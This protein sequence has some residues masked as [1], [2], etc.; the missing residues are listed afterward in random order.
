MI[1]N[2][3]AQAARREDLN[4][5]QIA[6]V[7]TYLLDE[8]AEVQVKA[9]FLKALS[10]K[11]ETA[12]EISAFVACCL[13]YAIDPQLDFTRFSGPTIDVCGTGGDQLDLFNVSTTSMF[14]IA[15]GGCTVMK[16]GNR[17][18]TSKSGGA[19][20]LEALGINIEQPAEKLQMI[21]EKAGVAFLFAPQY[22][23]AF[24][25][26]APVRQLLAK[27][28]VKTIFNLIGP[29]LNPA[30]PENQLIGV[31]KPEMLSVYPDILEE[32]G[33][34][35]AWVVQGKTA[36]GQPV[37]EVS[38][39][40][41]TQVNR[42]EE[43]VMSSLTVTPEE[44]GIK[45]VKVEELR[46]GGASENAEI[47]KGVLEG[48]IQGAKRQMVLANAAAGLAAAGV[49]DSLLAGVERARQLID[50]GMAYERLRQLQ[51]LS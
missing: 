17:G 49:V 33:R 31:S 21:L 13:K 22:H 27:E 20:V 35:R 46:G 36:D 14:V 45:R 25:A 8:K 16:H 26:V 1:N 6:E 43:G 50:G 10:K 39:M 29:L 28:G 2:L 19:D 41:P 38:V 30:R 9:D 15:A 51:D 44:L 11:G 3:I 48:S 4:A 7:V 42:V 18:V 37:D 47:L 40:G 32:L 24:K 12:A 23:P 5:A 34:K